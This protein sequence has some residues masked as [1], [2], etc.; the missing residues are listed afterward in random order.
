MNNLQIESSIKGIYLD[1][2]YISVKMPKAL[3]VILH[4]MSEHKERII[5]F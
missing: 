1:V 2:N 4:G 3:V 5:I